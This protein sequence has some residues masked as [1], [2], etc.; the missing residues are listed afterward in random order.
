VGIQGHW[1]LD[2]VPFEDIEAAIEIYSALGLRIAFTE[3]DI[4][5]VARPGCGADLAVQRA[6][7]PTE[8]VYRD[9]CPL[10]VLERQADQYAR[11]FE[12]LVGAVPRVTRATFWGLH[13]GKSWL[14]YWPGKRTN[15][16]LLFDRDCRP[17]PAWQRLRPILGSLPSG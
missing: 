9:G 14:N 2:Q 5:V 3:I 17:K 8:D 10:E 6:Y 15:H 7:A 12:I 13:D 4:D 16:P 1:Q 11:L